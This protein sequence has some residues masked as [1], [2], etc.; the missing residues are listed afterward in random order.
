MSEV[1]DTASHLVVVGRGKVVADTSV[2]ALISA[3]SGD[4]VNLH[5][6]ART[7]AM[8]AL[9]NA[10]A[11]VATTNRDT[12]TVSGLPAERIVAVLGQ[13]G[14]PFS[15]VAAHRATL[16]EAY[17]DLTRDAVEFRAPSTEEAAR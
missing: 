8:T 16:E 5:T 1:Q 12:I 6:S 15:E 4:R 14:V 9:A 17:M 7:E 11:T 3:A 2:A 10:G 13:A